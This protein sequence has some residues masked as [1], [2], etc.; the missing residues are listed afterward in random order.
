MGLGEAVG[1]G[2]IGGLMSAGAGALTQ[3][4]VSGKT[5]ESYEALLKDQLRKMRTGQL[6]SSA[7]EQ[8]LEQ[9]LA[10]G[11]QDIGQQTGALQTQ[12]AE[13][14][15][16]QQ[17]GGPLG[18][19]TGRGAALLRDIGTAAAEQAAQLSATRVPTLLGLSETRAGE[20]MAGLE[21][22]LDRMMDWGAALAGMAVEGAQLGM[23]AGWEYSPS[24]GTPGVPSVPGAETGAATSAATSAAPVA[25][26]WVAEELYGVDSP[27]THQ[28]RL[29]ARSH[30]SRFLRLYKNHGR[31]WADWLKKHPWAKPLV[32]P[33]WDRMAYKGRMMIC[34][35]YCG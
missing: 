4:A 29:Y 12:V 11:K 33:I 25:A 32:Q 9:N 35:V 3:K 2:A 10:K 5:K 18:T 26:C 20:A 31:A 15:L 21:R 34:E 27:K 28:A 8:A 6:V 14:Q 19:V 17:G 22:H 23:A 30:D 1:G 7:E 13:E 24:G 16:T